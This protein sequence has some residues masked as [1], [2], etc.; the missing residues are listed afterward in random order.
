LHGLE[1][2]ERL[3][4]AAPVRA[5]DLDAVRPPACEPRRDGLGDRAAVDCA[6]LHRERGDL[7]RGRYSGRGSAGGQAGERRR[8]V[9][10]RPRHGDAA[11]HEGRVG[12]AAG[13]RVDRDALG[14]EQRRGARHAETDSAQHENP[15]QRADGE[16]VHR[17][18]QAGRPLDAGRES[19]EDRPP[20]HPGAERRPSG[21]RRKR[22]EAGECEQHD[23]RPSPPRQ[24]GRRRARHGPFRS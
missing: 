6:A 17:E 9:K 23:G 3:E 7:D 12:Q 5:G 10:P 13:V 18:R 4:H 14:G 16:V 15:A 1:C 11:Q 2:G 22:G 19:V 24:A 8:E 20:A 21:D